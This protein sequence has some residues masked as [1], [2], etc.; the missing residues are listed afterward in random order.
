MAKRRERFYSPEEQKAELAKAVAQWEMLVRDVGVLAKAAG[1]PVYKQKGVGWRSVDA[2]EISLNKGGRY[3]GGGPYAGL[4]TWG[5]SYCRQYRVEIGTVG[6]FHGP[7]TFQRAVRNTTA[8]LLY[9]AL[10]E[11][12]QKQRD[13]HARKL[14]DEQKR[15]AA[16]QRMA[17]Q[18]KR[19]TALL[20]TKLRYLSGQGHIA[21]IETDTSGYAVHST[22]SVR[23]SEGASPEIR[24]AF[25][26]MV[27]RWRREAIS[28]QQPPKGDEP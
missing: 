25:E 13:H 19:D 6:R 16:E 24:E 11:Q 15:E 12:C 8:P 3:D 23:V 17:A 10:V 7:P 4:M 26:E 1:T 21:N 14:D 28:Y 27:R 5:K 2:I 22:F 18:Q 9:A 20:G